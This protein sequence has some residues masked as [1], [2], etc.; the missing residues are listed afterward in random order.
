MAPRHGES[1]K[2]PQSAE[3][4]HVSTPAGRHN[5]KSATSEPATPA[6]PVSDQE[7]EIGPELEQDHSRRPRERAMPTLNAIGITMGSGTRPIATAKKQ[8]AINATAAGLRA[9]GRPSFTAVATS[10]PAADAPTPVTT[11]DTSGR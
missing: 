4:T 5:A 9:I 6:T 2:R 1:R 7:R 10:R 11:A 8:P 3:T